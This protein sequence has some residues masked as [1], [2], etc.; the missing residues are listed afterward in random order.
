MA[1]QRA[2]AAGE[3]VRAL[4]PPAV[5]LGRG[6]GARAWLGA[7]VLR[8]LRGTAAG[9]VGAW[10]NVPFTIMMAAT[11]AVIGALVGLFHGSFLGPQ[12]VARV[13]RLLQ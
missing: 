7:I 6:P 12:I 4:V 2:P 3:W 13:D 11:G 5:R 1:A 10:F 8:N 9:I